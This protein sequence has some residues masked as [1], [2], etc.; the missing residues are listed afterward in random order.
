MRYV[1]VPY[2]AVSCNCLQ[3][4]V[5]FSNFLLS[6]FSIF[7]FKK[8]VLIYMKQAVQSVKIILQNR[9]RLVNVTKKRKENLIHHINIV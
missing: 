7:R 2:S 8:Y 6:L 9:C 5:S 1:K 3:L 4:S